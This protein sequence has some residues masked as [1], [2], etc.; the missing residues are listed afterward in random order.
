[1]ETQFYEVRGRTA[2]F[3]RIISR[4]QSDEKL[5]LAILNASL[6][7][8]VHFLYDYFNIKNADKESLMIKFSNS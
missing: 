8:I 2:M 3:A 7:L 1:M 4:P 6:Q 5:L